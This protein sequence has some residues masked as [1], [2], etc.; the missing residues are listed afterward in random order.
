MIIVMIIIEMF[1]LIKCFKNDNHLYDIY[2]ARYLN[3][4]IIVML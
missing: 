1:K 2:A 3:N 4:Y